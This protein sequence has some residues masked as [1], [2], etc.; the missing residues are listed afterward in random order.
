MLLK[1]MQT[2]LGPQERLDDLLIGGLKIIQNEAEFC[3]SL[4]AVLL[5]HFASVKKHSRVLDLGT[6]TG[7]IPLLLAAQAMQIDALELNPVMADLAA[8]NVELNALQDKIN[9]RKGDLCD[10]REIYPPEFFDLV[11]SNPPYRPLQHGMVNDLDGVARA[12]HEITATLAD[13]VRA[14]RYVLK[15][16]SR[17]AMVHLPERLGEI[18]IA[19]HENKIEPK[20]LCFVHS[21]LDKAPTMV[22]IEGI[23][24]ANPGGLQVE[25]PILVHK[26]DGSYTDAIRKYF[27]EEDDNG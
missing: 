16:R 27:Y 14:A 26:E 10:I 13:V 8:R 2:E 12:R 9:V 19:M 23:V 11:V 5:A 17:F 18:I 7:V 21:R 20:R 1:K 24:G 25:P 22:L 6:G 3:F 4:D 15:F